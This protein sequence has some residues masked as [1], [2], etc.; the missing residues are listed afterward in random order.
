M[1][2]LKV[3]VNIRWAVMLSGVLFSACQTD[4]VVRVADTAYYP[5]EKGRFWVYEVSEEVFS[6]TNKPETRHYWIKE[7]IGNMIEDDH[8]NRFYQLVRYKKNTLSEDWKADSVWL[9]RPL[10]DKLIRIENNVSFTKL[11]FPA[12]EGSEWN[13][14]ALNTAEPQELKYVKVG[15]SYQLNETTL[16]PRTLKVSTVNDSTALTMDRKTDV[17]ALEKGLIYKEVISLT[18]CQKSECIGAGIID[19]GKKTFWT[20][21]ETGL[22]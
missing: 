8:Y 12:E 3:F 5:V 1:K 21:K 9:I 20:L 13:T 2:S 10:P 6:L 11:I 4:D 7:S 17:Y 14:N 18:Y 19:F 15:G 16:Y 22:E